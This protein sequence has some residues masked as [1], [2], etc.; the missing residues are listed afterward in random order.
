MAY[1]IAV[2]SACV[3]RIRNG[4]TVYAVSQSTG[5]AF[6]TIERWWLLERQASVSDAT[7]IARN[8]IIQHELDELDALK[9]QVIEN[10][11]KLEEIAKGVKRAYERAL[12]AKGKLANA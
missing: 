4:E 1:S 11:R 6:A 7:T 5:I 2:R 3:K 12:S 10:A 9:R 8:E